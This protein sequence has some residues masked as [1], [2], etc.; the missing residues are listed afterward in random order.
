MVRFIQQLPPGAQLGVISSYQTIEVKPAQLH[1]EE[2]LQQ[3]GKE[4]GRQGDANQREGGDGII[5]SGILLGRSNDAQRNGNHQLQRKGDQ[6]H[7]KAQPNGL[8][9]LR[10]DG[11]GILPAV[12]ELALNCIAQPGEV[13][14][15]NALIQAIGRIELTKPFVIA[16]CTG[17]RGQ[18][19][20]H[21]LHIRAWQTS[22]KSIDDECH[23]NQNQDRQQDSFDDILSQ[24]NPSVFDILEQYIF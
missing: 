20:G 3:G 24:G 6:A 14:G 8:A 11:L 18:L 16:L 23:A 17:F 1:R 22:Q 10:G 7:N 12:A 13:A 19:H 21:I 2:Q 5:R 9:E 15:Y 4:E